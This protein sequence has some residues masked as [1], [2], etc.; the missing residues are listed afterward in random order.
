MFSEIGNAIDDLIWRRKFRVRMGNGGWLA[1]LD[2]ATPV[3]QRKVAIDKSMTVNSIADRGHAQPEILK[4]RAW[5][6]TFNDPRFS[7]Q[8]QA[9]QLSGWT[10]LLPFTDNSLSFLSASCSIPTS[11]P[12]SSEKLHCTMSVNASASLSRFAACCCI[13]TSAL[14]TGCTRLGQFQATG[15]WLRVRGIKRDISAI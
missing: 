2:H 15:Y 11:W 12:P 14:T 13:G 3:D 1:Y 5:F 4:Y 8:P 10:R 9:V 7:R 6:G